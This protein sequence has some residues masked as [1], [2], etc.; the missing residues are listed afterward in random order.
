ML[1]ERYLPGRVFVNREKFDQPELNYDAYLDQLVVIRN[2]VEAVVSQAMVTEFH[3]TSGE[4][5]VVFEKLTTEKK[6]PGYFQGLTKKDS[7]HCL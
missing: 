2:G 3:L 7:L 1:F 4:D 6:D 5:T